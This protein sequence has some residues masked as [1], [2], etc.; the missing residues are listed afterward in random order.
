MSA[1]DKPE[2]E[3]KL[4]TIEDKIDQLSEEEQEKVWQITELFEKAWSK[5]RASSN[6]S[7]DEMARALDYG[8]NYVRNGK[9][10]FFVGEDIV[11]RVLGDMLSPYNHRISTPLVQ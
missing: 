9:I 6:L 5:G 1:E 7:D 8:M 10:L 4:K 3:D 2:T 11:S